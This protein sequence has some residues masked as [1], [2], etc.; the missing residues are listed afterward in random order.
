MTFSPVVRARNV[1]LITCYS[2]A[3]A[4][5]GYWFD[6]SLLPVLF[7][8]IA[9]PMVGLVLHTQL[10]IARVL[11]GVAVLASVVVI[12]DG[13]ARSTGS[14][15]TIGSLT[16]SP[17]LGVILFAFFHTLYTVV[18]YEYLF[19]DSRLRA[20]NRTRMATL[21]AIVGSLL[22]G[23]LYVFG[24]VVVSFGFLWLLAALLIMLLGV[25]LLIPT[26]RAK[27]LVY[28]DLAFSAV[29]WPLS[30]IFEFALLTSG[31][32]LFAFQS[33][34]L[35]SL[36]LF[37]TLVP[38]EEIILLFLWPVVLVILYEGLIDDRR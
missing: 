32:R 27:A 10:P 31:E 22:V 25:L 35:Y 1:V 23:G 8:L 30:V 14:W 3:V 38:I 34:Y 16:A 24:A 6:I 36:S 17:Y 13:L 33:E 7:L 9:V 2:A 5:T 37:G 11:G 19:D 12:L 15:Y 18:L 29:L 20:L 28:K 26:A 21:A 4:V